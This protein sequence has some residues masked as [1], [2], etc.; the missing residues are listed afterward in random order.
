MAKI[1][2]K[3]F[4]FKE[5]NDKKIL[6]GIFI[7]VFLLFSIN[8]F[9]LFSFVEKDKKVEEIKTTD[10]YLVQ[11]I[12]NSCSKGNLFKNADCV[13][14]EVLKFYKYNFSN[15]ENELNL[16]SLIAYGGT[17]EGWSNLFCSLGG[18]LG[19]YN[20]LVEF[21]T[22]ETDEYK[23]YHQ[24]CVWSSDEGYVILDEGM[25]FKAKFNSSSI[26]DIGDFY[27]SR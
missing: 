12:I 15:K 26:D 10:V 7:L 9:L 21:K 24:F 3:K 19:Y 2:P 27:G 5:K 14:E 17:C 22:R 16:N 25:I 1:N 23:L 6:W 8:F 20:T 13:N 11:N 18:K 4:K